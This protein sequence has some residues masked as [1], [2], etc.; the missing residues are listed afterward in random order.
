MNNRIKSLVFIFLFGII[1]TLNA[2]ATY[3]NR[4]ISLEGMW[5]FSI[6]DNEQ[7]ANPDFDDSDWDFIQVPSDWDDYYEGY[8][9]FGWYRKEFEVKYVPTHEQ[10]AFILGHIDDVD[11][12]Y[13]NGEK[14]GQSGVFPP[15]YESAYDVNR[16]YKIESDLLNV[17]KNTIAVRVYDGALN[18]GM[19]GSVDIGLFYDND[20]ALVDMDMSGIWKFSIYRQ[21]GM[22]DYEYDDSKWSNIEVPGIWEE[23]GFPDFNGY[24]WYRTKFTVPDNMLNRKIYLV[25]GKIDDLDKVFLNGKFLART[26]DLKGDKPFFYSQTRDLYRV[27]EISENDLKKDNILVVEVKDNMGQGGIFEGPVGLMHPANADILIQRNAD[28]NPDSH[29]Y[30]DSPVR[31]FFREIFR[32]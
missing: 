19:T 7:W 11:E 4:V 32:F 21:S 23:Q 12:V 2:S 5:R 1:C 10:M 30:I 29:F 20:M 26:E 31:W 27:Y 28:L 9:G 6:G 8:N 3:W 25:L 16:I 13:V 22:Y 24:A 18:G 15:E 14:I 17:G